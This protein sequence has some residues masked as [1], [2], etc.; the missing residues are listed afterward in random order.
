MAAMTRQAPSQPSRDTGTSGVVLEVE[1]F[2]VHDGPGIRTVVFLKGC[3]LA[4]S[5][6]HNPEA[7]EFGPQLLPGEARCPACGQRAVAMATCQACGSDLPAVPPR[8]VGESMSV[9]ELA[10]Q[11]LRHA[12]VLDG[13]G[14]GVTFS[15]GE[16]MAQ[17]D[18][19]AAVAQAVQP[20]HVAVETSG[21]VAGAVFRRV[22]ASM[23]LVM[24]DVKHT[25]SR[26][27]RRFTGRDNHTVLANLAQLCAGTTPFVVR[28]PLI[29]G[30]NDDEANLERTAQLV[31]DAPAL[32][33]V[34]LLPYNTMAPAK[35]PRAGRQF[36][37]GFDTTRA[38]RVDRTVFER[39][40]IACEVL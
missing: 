13:S 7:I 23:D 36:R 8:L 1:E 31:A 40:D 9:D 6:C 3:P 24:I 34:E 28:V 18:F 15:G 20:L 30:V 17:A 12:H 4:C 19:V 39:Y 22:A 2:G 5:W 32:R 33:G 21:Q 25:D 29:P 14:G 35:Y 37:P 26:V 16:P 11:L 27:H 38:P 10:A